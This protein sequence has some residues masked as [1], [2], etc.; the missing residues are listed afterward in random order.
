MLLL[1]LLL[2]LLLIA[3]GATLEPGKQLL[4]VGHGEGSKGRSSLLLAKAANARISLLAM[5]S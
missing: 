4:Q 1:R 3:R 2:L 5:R